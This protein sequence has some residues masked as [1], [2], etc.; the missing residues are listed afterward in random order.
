M[1]SDSTVRRI[2]S[3]YETRHGAPFPFREGALLEKTASIF[4]LSAQSNVMMQQRGRDV[5][6][7]IEGLP[8]RAGDRLLDEIAEH[9]PKASFSLTGVHNYLFLPLAARNVIEGESI[10]SPTVLDSLVSLDPAVFGTF[11]KENCPYYG[12]PYGVHGLPVSR[13]VPSLVLD[14]PAKRSYRWL[15]VGS[16]LKVFPVS[17]SE[18]REPIKLS[19]T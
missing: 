15:D 14:F 2:L 10:F 18:R 9:L 11:L 12:N 7:H 16:G 17:E 5:L 13:H 19:H 4:S 1:M 8:A 6:R 3:R